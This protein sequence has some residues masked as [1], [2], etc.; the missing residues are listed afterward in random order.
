MALALW[1]KSL[2]LYIYQNET[3]YHTFTGGTGDPDETFI[4]APNYFAGNTGDHEFTKWVAPWSGSLVK[5]VVNAVS[6]A[7]NSTEMKLYAGVDGTTEKDSQTV[8]M[9]SAD[10]SYTFNFES[11]STIN[12]GDLIK[13]SVDATGPG[14][15]TFHVACVWKYKVTE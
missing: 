15:S 5:A 14:A 6:T 11:G 7:P 1:R 2:Y 4:P 13:V 3:T 9:S 10:T 12:P 8:N